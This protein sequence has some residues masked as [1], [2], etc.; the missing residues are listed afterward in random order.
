MITREKLEQARRMDMELAARRGGL[1]TFGK[2]G[3]V[4][5][6]LSMT[7]VMNAV[8]NEGRGVLSADAEGYWEDQDR[9]EFGINGKIV[10]SARVMR[11]RF[12]R[13]SFRK[14]YA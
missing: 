7:A 11:N 5:R 9:R 13:V 3:R 6:Q 1:Q 10:R 8:D 4:T 12:G 14:V 2:S